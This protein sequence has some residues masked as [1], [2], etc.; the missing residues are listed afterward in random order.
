[1]MMYHISKERVTTGFVPRV[2]EIRMDGEDETIPRI[3]V[4]DSVEGCFSAIPNGGGRLEDLQFETQGFYYL[5]TFDISSFQTEDVVTAKTLFEK[6]LVDDAYLNG[7]HWLLK[8]AIPIKEE[9]IWLYEW[10]ETSED[11][12]PY[13]V[14]RLLDDGWD[15]E[16]AYETALPDF[17]GEIPFMTSIRDLQY[18]TDSL[19]KNK[20]VSFDCCR[21]WDGLAEKLTEI[22]SDY[23]QPTKFGYLCTKKD[24]PLHLLKEWAEAYV[25]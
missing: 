9:L 22:A 8:E 19:E 16:E 4:C 17:N 2:P 1:M 6:V 18:A 11:L 25:A 14:L 12:H 13:E 7:E 23:V 3:C 24:L 21:D 15:L 5:Y 10:E 20:Q